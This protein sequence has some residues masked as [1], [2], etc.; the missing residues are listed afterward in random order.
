M[1]VTAGIFLASILLK[2]MRYLVPEPTART[3]C[4][5]TNSPRL[6]TPGE[7]KA[8]AKSKV[9]QSSRALTNDQRSWVGG[10]PHWSK[11]YGK[12]D[13]NFKRHIFGKSFHIQQAWSNFVWRN[14]NNWFT[15]GNR[16]MFTN[17]VALTFCL[18]K[19]MNYRSS[20]F[21]KLP[22]NLRKNLKM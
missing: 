6:F 20:K 11:K 4:E 1:G 22:F 5:G 12:Q 18:I 7:T 14:E 2:E 13:F 19:N 9:N 8:L 15:T 21:H 16:E 17:F 3:P 10:H